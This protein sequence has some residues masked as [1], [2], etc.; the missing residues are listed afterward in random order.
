MRSIKSNRCITVITYQM[1][2]H[3]F[4]L[5]GCVCI[6]TGDSIRVLNVISRL[7]WIIYFC[8]YISNCHDPI[9]NLYKLIG[10]CCDI[11]H[12]GPENGNETQKQHNKTKQ[13]EHKKHTTKII[14]RVILLDLPG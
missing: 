6:V 13:T 9:C 12:V 2:F 4:P 7:V 14:D 1:C 8:I 5:M 11:F 10:K 3:M